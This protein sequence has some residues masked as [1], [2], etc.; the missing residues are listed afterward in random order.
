M[1]LPFIVLA[2]VLLQ[3]IS[4]AQ[5]KLDFTFTVDSESFES[6]RKFYVHVPDR[7]VES[8]RDT[9]GVV[10]VLDAQSRSFYDNAKS[11]IDY[12]VWGYQITPVIVVGIHTENRGNE[13]IPKNKSL[14]E[15]DEN[16]SGQA[17]QLRDHIKNEIFPIIR[18]SFRVNDFKA[19]IGHSRG[20]AFIANTVFGEDRDMFNGYIAISPAM[21]YLDRQILKEAESQIQA[22]VEFNKFYYCSYGTVGENERYFGPQV[23]YLDSLWSAHPN[24]SVEWRT[25]EFPSSTHWTVVAA[26]IVDGM[27]EM[28]RVYTT[29]QY[30]VETMVAAG[31]NIRTAINNYESMQRRKLKFGIPVNAGELSYFASQFM[32]EENHSVAMDLI[33]ESIARDPLYFRAYTIKAYAYSTLGKKDKAIETCDHA[34]SLINANADSLSEEVVE[35]WTSRITGTKEDISSKE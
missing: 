8:T 14:D 21:H 10:Y 34:L 5:P 16:N 18:D 3:S 4:T 15:N 31:Q 17:Q 32:E 6:E 20:G 23:Q 7:Y 33:E 13:F 29:D 2:M 30:T 12:L 1:R 25:K 24:E 28:N 19:I 26:S 11:I 27:Q 22:N 9:F 35:R